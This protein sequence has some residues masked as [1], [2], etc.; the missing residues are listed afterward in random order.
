MSCLLS[1]LLDWCNTLLSGSILTLTCTVSLCSHTTP[2]HKH[3]MFWLHNWLVACG[4]HNAWGHPQVVPWWWMGFSILTSHCNGPLNTPFSIC[5]VFYLCT[6][7][8]WQL[9]SELLIGYR[10]EAASG[11]GGMYFSL[12]S[13]VL[14]GEL[15]LHTSSL[16]LTCHH[17]SKT[18]RK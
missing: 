13:S 7:S 9:V 8:V 17:L 11:L 10:Q 14:T 2:E 4:S 18:Q 16:L 3:F 1:A 5:Y 12:L 6:A 15:Q